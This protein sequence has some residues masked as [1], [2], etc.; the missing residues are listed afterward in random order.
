MSAALA[1]MPHEGQGDEFRHDGG[2][3]HDGYTPTYM[4]RKEQVYKGILL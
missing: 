1:L 2:L 3:F 4:A